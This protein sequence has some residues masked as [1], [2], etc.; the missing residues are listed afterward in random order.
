MQFVAFLYVSGF[1]P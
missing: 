1:N